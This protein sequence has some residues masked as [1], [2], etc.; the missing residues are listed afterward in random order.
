MAKISIASDRATTSVDQ[1]AIIDPA[2]G[3]VPYQ[4]W[5][6]ARQKRAGSRL[7][8]PTKPE[9]IDTQHRCLISG[10]PRLYTIVPSFRIIQTPGSVVFV[11]DDITRIG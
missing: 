6:A 3:L 1:V 8:T 11:W 4:P 5:A 10:V 2:D 9:H 7:R